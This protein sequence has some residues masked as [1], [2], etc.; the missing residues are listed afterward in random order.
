[1]TAVEAVE[2]LT[3]DGLRLQAEM[4]TPDNST[5]AAVLAH[6]HPEHGG[7]MNNA[8]IKALFAGLPTHGATVL[9]F[10]FRGVDGSE[11][12]HQQGRFERLDVHAA[13]DTMAQMLDRSIQGIIVVGY[14]FGADVALTVDHLAAGGW[15]AIAPPLSLYPRPDFVAASDGRAVRV[16]VPEND[17]FA[18]PDVVR[19]RLT[20]WSNT[21]VGVVPDAD[22]LLAGAGSTL[23]DATADFARTVFGGA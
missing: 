4:A 7:N 9:R 1:M 5:W 11:G 8:V 15:L 19:E 17:Q 2:V 10:N 3:S 23:V 6:P 21:E 14:S 22:H 13:L 16:L 18:P 20:G 12:E